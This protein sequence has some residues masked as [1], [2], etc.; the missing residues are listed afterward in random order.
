M[1]ETCSAAVLVEYERPLEIRSYPVPG[2]LGPDEL[3]VRVEM[4]GICGTDVHLWLGQ[5]PIPLPVILG[6]ETAG[7]LEKL[8]SSL[9]KDWRGNTLREAGE[10]ISGSAVTWW[11]GDYSRVEPPCPRCEGRR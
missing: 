6:H 8:G 1:P 3:L 7:R 2:D 4:A 9:Q 11:G 5:L 10:S